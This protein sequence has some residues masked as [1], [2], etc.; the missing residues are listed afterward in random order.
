MRGTRYKPVEGP[1]T[2]GAAGPSVWATW[3]FLVAAI[4]IAL[5]L[6]GIL[7]STSI[8]AGRVA[9][10]SC[11]AFR[12]EVPFVCGVNPNAIPRV[13]P[14][15][16]ATTVHV[17]NP[18][19]GTADFWKRVSL[20]FPPES[21]SP[22][23]LSE[24]LDDSLGEMR[25]LMVDCE[26]IGS[27]FGIPPGPPYVLGMVLIQSKVS[28]AVWAEQTAAKT[29]FFVPSVHLGPAEMNGPMSNV[30]NVTTMAVYRARERCL[31]DGTFLDSFY[32]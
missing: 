21:Q 18:G 22:G 9:R 28:L 30:L 6:I 15:S 7:V 4:V 25:T 16:Y 8:N 5:L 23:F 13:M 12:Y 17:H 11:D 26:E 31:V 32:Q 24:A 3:V 27:E 2:G 1:I 29:G 10:L 20:D 19:S 14:G